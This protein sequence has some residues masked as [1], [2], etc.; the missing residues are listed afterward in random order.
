MTEGS[1]GNFYGIDSS[2]TTCR[3]D[4]GPGNGL[5][6]GSNGWLYGLFGSPAP[7]GVFAID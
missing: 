6:L 2:P 3:Q 7:G 5:A 4:Y 1:D